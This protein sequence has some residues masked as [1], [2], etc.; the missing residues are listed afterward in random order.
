EDRHAGGAGSTVELRVADARL[1]GHLAVAGPSPQ[2]EY[3]LVHL[4]EA[5][6]TDGLAVGDQATVGVDGEGTVDLEN[7]VGD[8]LL[9]VTVG[10]EAVLGQMDDL[11]AC[12]G[13][14]ELD[15]V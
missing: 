10:T 3:D 7:A 14:L 13:V 5:R 9:L 12:V 6:R 15:D 8:Q 2:L 4:A 11:G 1:P